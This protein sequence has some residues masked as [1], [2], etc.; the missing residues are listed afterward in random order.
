MR[1]KLFCILFGLTA[2]AAHAD[3]KPKYLTVWSKDGGKQA[4]ALQR[5]PEISFTESDLVVTSD[6]A[7]FSYPLTELLRFT[8]EVHEEETGINGIVADDKPFELNGE[9]ICFFSLKAQSQILVCGTDGRV[10][11]SR[12]LPEAGNYR[13]PLSGLQPGTYIVS[14]NGVTSKIVK[15]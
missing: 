1:Q 13:F 15:R 3:Q 7:D 8:Y 6:N 5:L 10:I 14:V 9:Y 12:H 11:L 2:L 4:Y